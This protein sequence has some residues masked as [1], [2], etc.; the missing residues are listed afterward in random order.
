MRPLRLFLQ[1]FGPYL[2]PTELD[3]TQFT[4]TGLFL[5]T[6]P[7]GGGKTSLLDA[8]CF[9]LYCRA[10][11]G[12]RTFS[13][14]RC[15]SAGQDQPTVVEFDFSLQGEEYR[16]RR[17]IF[18]R[19][20]RN[21]KLPQPR[22]SHQCFRREQGEFVLL[23]SGSESA[24]R[25][26]AEELLHL[27][28][29]QFSQVIVLPQGDFLRLLRASSQEK[30]DMLRTLFSAQVWT[31]IKDKFQQRAK[32]LEEDS[33]RLQAMKESLLTQ[34]GAA[35]PQELSQSVEALEASLGQ[36]WALPPVRLECFLR[37]PLHFGVLLW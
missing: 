12:R 4:D 27:S 8:M 1:A 16:F 14:M 25:R 24:V 15:M 36:R 26:R 7:T 28:C 6:G 5:I 31:D 18:L 2:E 22:D 32:A 13:S 11:G 33:R 9:A 3:F 17:S 23:E 30:G 34:E 21:T 37:N 19:V 10:T 35:T 29:E 20:N